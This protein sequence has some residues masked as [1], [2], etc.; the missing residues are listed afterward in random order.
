M[1]ILTLCVIIQDL[2]RQLFWRL[3]WYSSA[4]PSKLKDSTSEQAAIA[5]FYNIDVHL[6][7]ET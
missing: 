7:D 3:S 5:P 6:L 1:N 4:A 2:V